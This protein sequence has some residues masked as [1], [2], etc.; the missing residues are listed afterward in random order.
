M[1]S[2]KVPLNNGVL[3][4]QVGFGLYKVPPVDAA[5]LCLQALE[6][7]YRHLDTAALYANEAGVG[8][9]VHRFTAEETGLSREDIFITTKVW[10]DHHGFDAAL[11][12]YDRSL[13]E[14]ALDYV[15]L[16][17][18]H[19]PRPRHGKFI[20]TYRALE[21]LY[22]EG[23][24]RA[25]G[26]SNFT[27]HHLEQLLEATEVVPAVNQVELHPWLQQAELRAFHDRHG[28]RTEAW[29]PLGRGMVL[30][31]PVVQEL[32]RDLGRTP[33]QVI[34][35]WHLQ[36]GNIVIPKA[37]SA[38]RLRE[39]FDLAGFSLDEDAMQRMAGLERDGRI[40]SDP[41]EVN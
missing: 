39:N 23:R 5:G 1:R 27:I 33:A 6:I 36:L 40:G 24:V 2:E 14:L 41:D 16:Y 21:R 7:G 35:R 12:A 8:Q 10:N 37:S 25:I 30:A 34:L 15:D 9:A 11:H 32:A 4:D 20:E 28:I 31:D 19:W 29:S 17:L 18:I 26:V 3:M 13:K 38:A 22:H